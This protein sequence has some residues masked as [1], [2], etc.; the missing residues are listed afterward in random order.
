MAAFL[1]VLLVGWIASGIVGAVIGS[2]RNSGGAG[3]AL[4]L[5]FG[6]LG[7]IAAFALDGRSVCPECRNK[8]DAGIR[9]CPTCRA[10]LAWYE[11]MVGTPKT[12]DLWR[13]QHRKHIQNKVAAQ[14][15]LRE[16]RERQKAAFQKK[17]SG[18]AAAVWAILQSLCRGIL[19]VLVFPLVAV[20]CQLW[21]MADG[22]KVAYRFMWV[23]CFVLIPITLITGLGVVVWAARSPAASSIDQPSVNAEPRPVAAE[24]RP[25]AAEMRPMPEMPPVPDDEEDGVA[26]AAVLPAVEPEDPDNRQAQAPVDAAAK[27]LA[28][29]PGI[30]GD[31]PVAVQKPVDDIEAPALRQPEDVAPV[32]EN[33]GAAA[34]AP[35]PG[36]VD[37]GEINRQAAEMQERADRKKQIRTLEREMQELARKRAV[38][39]QKARQA[40]IEG[41][42]LD[43]LR[44]R[45]GIPFGGP[46]PA[47]FLEEAEALLA[48]IRSLRT[49]VDQL[50]RQ[51]SRPPAR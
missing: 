44:A 48:R 9:L 50:K 18:I 51:G 30:E 20:N 32:G 15:R 40:A 47:L 28:G 35:R 5:F 31:R 12:V 1:P 39:Q 34:A 45:T 42:E 14:Q 19:R 2:R 13:M 23:G 43:A 33:D 24:V 4:G 38:A 25:I 3:F 7:A 21:E 10:Q 27:P 6:P 22:S 29:D 26:D 11:G 49:Q 17:L 36:A 8:I 16:E 46:S 41:A 37:G